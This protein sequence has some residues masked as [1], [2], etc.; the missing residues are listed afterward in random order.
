MGIYIR[1]DVR[2]SH[3]SSLFSHFLSLGFFES[4][5]FSSYL[6]DFLQVFKIFFKSSRFSSNLRVF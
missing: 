1:R 4:S 3:F 5:R 2:D 6:Q